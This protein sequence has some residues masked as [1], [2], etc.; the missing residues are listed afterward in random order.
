[1]TKVNWL[2]KDWNPTFDMPSFAEMRD[3]MPKANQA[4]DAVKAVRR[5][6]KVLRDKEVE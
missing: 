1:M 5:A 2:P 6:R 4:N 3:D